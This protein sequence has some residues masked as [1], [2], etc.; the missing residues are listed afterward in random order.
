M[1]VTNSA[2]VEAPRGELTL[3]RVFNAPRELVFK[4]WTDP[5]H[6]SQ[7]WGPG[8]FTNPV[9]EVDPRPGGALY[10][11]M[12]A[13]D[14]MEHT[15]SGVF[16]EI[17]SPERLVFT[18]NA[19]DSEGNLLLEG[20]TKVYFEDQGGKTKLTL[21]TSVVGLVEIAAQMIK[22]MEAGWSQ[23][24]DRLQEHVTLVSEGIALPVSE[25]TTSE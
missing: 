4:A 2:G 11:I 23:S 17:V 8:M 10:I 19:L 3:I 18:N 20:L 6:L 24:L 16:K 21:E 13:P 5:K 14:G 9:C 7:W 12:R 15:V 1:A 22:G 25:E